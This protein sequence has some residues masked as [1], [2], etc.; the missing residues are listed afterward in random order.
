MRDSA[1]EHPRELPLWTEADRILTGPNAI[2]VMRVLGVKRS[3]RTFVIVDADGLEFPRA[4]QGA[5]HHLSLLSSDEARGR[6]YC[7][8][9]GWRTDTRARFGERRLLPPVEAGDCCILHDAGVDPPGVGCGC[10]LWRADGTAVPL[11]GLED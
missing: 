10:Y 7:D 8:V 4:L 5:V 6:S 11:R 3:H 1:L 2:L 9:V